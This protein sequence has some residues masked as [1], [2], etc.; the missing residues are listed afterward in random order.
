MNEEIFDRLE[1]VLPGYEKRDSQV[2]LSKLVA[3][4]LQNK[5]HAAFEA[6]TGVGKSLAYLVGAYEEAR[7]SR[8]VIS[9]NSLTLQSQ[10]MKK[11][12]PLF[13]KALRDDER[14][15]VAVLKGRTHYVCL[16]RLKFYYDKNKEKEIYVELWDL[17]N[18]QIGEDEQYNFLVPSDIWAKVTCDSNSCLRDQ[19]AFFT[20]CFYYR[21][22]LAATQANFV[23]VNHHLF[24][25][26]RQIRSLSG[27]AL[28]PD[29]DF[30]VLD[31]AHEIQDIASD[32]FGKKLTLGRVRRLLFDILNYQGRGLLAYWQDIDLF[33]GTYGLLRDEI[34]E[35]AD[36]FFSNIKIRAKS[37][38]DR[39]CFPDSPLLLEKFEELSVLL[40][41]LTCDT[42]VESRMQS[43]TMDR[44][45][46]LC[47][48]FREIINLEDQAKKVYYAKR[49]DDRVDLFATPIVVSDLLDYYVWCLPSVVCL[50]ATLASS[51]SDFSYFIR[52]TGFRGITEVF[53]SP[54]NF[55]E[56]VCR[57]I[58]NLPY[59]SSYG[60]TDRKIYEE[61]ITS[62]IKR[63]LIR[64]GG[65]ALVLFTNRDMMKRIYEVLGD[66]KF[67]NSE[68][69]CQGEQYPR[70]EMIR[71]FKEDEQS[72]IF[73]LD[74][75]WQGIDVKGNALFQVIL[76]KLPFEH[77]DDPVISARTQRYGSQ[78]FIQYSVPKAIIQ[79]KQ[80]FGRLIRSKTDRGIFSILDSRVKTT[81][82]G[83]KFLNALPLCSELDKD[84]K[85]KRV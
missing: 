51:G 67:G 5:Q 36:E 73:G 39:D 84:L 55:R 75:F 15:R 21:A 4:A 9:T 60:E 38:I 22:K 80:G 77:P 69:M 41:E 46:E 56:Q 53:A 66:M 71:I 18:D 43:R 49:Q 3:L 54:F 17:A 72:V 44:V 62:E 16:E 48:D 61:G 10:L 33:K 59:I 37:L 35:L 58:T 1:R 65:R 70:D 76:V 20:S 83:S 82:W 14:V 29:Y 32:V 25:L 12:V 68:I 78:S 13:N 7:R 40:S 79:F 74:S 27:R 19:C 52:E 23:I 8:V 30:A 2:R 11:D 26:D 85:P 42:E 24:L 28:L 57:Y 45:L 47:R 63:L 6:P 64:T 81:R 34:L 50:S 31:E